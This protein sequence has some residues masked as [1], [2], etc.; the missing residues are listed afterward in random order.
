MKKLIL[1]NDPGDPLLYGCIHFITSPKTKE[2]SQQIIIPPKF[3]ANKY[4]YRLFS[5]LICGIIYIFF[6][7]SVS[8]SKKRNKLLKNVFISREGVLRIKYFDMNRY[9]NYIEFLNTSLKNGI[10]SF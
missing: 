6:I 3:L 8:I 7:P 10:E 5:T 4:G 9:W 2:F 1:N